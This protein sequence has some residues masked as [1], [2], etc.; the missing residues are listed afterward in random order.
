MR[1]AA[2]LVFGLLAALIAPVSG[3]AAAGPAVRVEMGDPTFAGRTWTFQP[4]AY[5]ADDNDLGGTGLNP[6]FVDVPAGTS[7]NNNSTLGTTTVTIGPGS[8]AMKTLFMIPGSSTMF[9]EMTF[10]LL[11][12][13][14]DLNGAPGVPPAGWS[15]A[16]HVQGFGVT[17]ADA[18]VALAEP[19]RAEYR[20][21]GWNTAA[22]GSGHAVDA[23][24]DVYGFPAMTLFA[25]WTPELSFSGA[26]IGSVAGSTEPFSVAG[27]GDVSGATLSTT[28]PAASIDQTAREIVF[29]TA[30]THAVTASLAGYVQAETTVLVAAGLAD[31]LRIA[32][33]ASSV[34]QGGSLDFTVTAMDEFGNPVAVDPA[35]VQLTSSVPGDVIQG[36]RVSFPHAS[37]HTITAAVGVLRAST[38]IEVIPTPQ[39]AAT[40]A[41]AVGSSTI[42]G[43]AA[44]A[45]LAAGAML[46]VR[47]RR[48]G[49]DAPPCVV[50]RI[51]AR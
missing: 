8:D 35:H 37:P 12:V 10:A 2:T 21:A 1:V 44:F 41:G 7:V 40:G 45:L 27:P 46:L 38:T 4:R 13:S 23:Q 19:V 5:D 36:L 47:P 34:E 50:S 26:P 32:A 18:G 14:F 17:L 6:V 39:L 3:A 33:P 49:E 16:V 30:G 29:R 43:L 11:D 31:R 48:A 25:Q 24:A 28:D 9:F 51:R 22:D 42:Y 15:G 20:F